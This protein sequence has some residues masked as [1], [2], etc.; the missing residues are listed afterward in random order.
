[1]KWILLQKMF[2]ILTGVIF[3]GMLTLGGRNK[4]KIFFHCL[5]NCKLLQKQLVLKLHGLR[6][7][8]TVAHFKRNPVGKYALGE[9]TEF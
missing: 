7:K 3:N 5:N 1:M 9:Q 2:H 4:I 8:G 6:N